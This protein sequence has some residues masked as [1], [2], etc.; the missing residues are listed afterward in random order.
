MRPKGAGMTGASRGIW[1]QKTNLFQI[2]EAREL[3]LTIHL[4][5]GDCLVGHPWLVLVLR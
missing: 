4:G 1:H 5:K 2:G 3:S